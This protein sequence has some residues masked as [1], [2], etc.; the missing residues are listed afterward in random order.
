MKKKIFMQ[1]KKTKYKSILSFLSPSKKPKQPIEDK[2]LT[3]STNTNTDFIST[4]TNEPQCEENESLKLLKS[5]DLES[6]ITN[7]S[8]F[9]LSSEDDI[10]C[11][12]EPVIDSSKQTLPSLIYT[13]KQNNNEDSINNSS[14]NGSLSFN[15][16]LDF[17]EDLNLKSLHK[18]RKENIKKLE[19]EGKNLYDLPFNHPKYEKYPQIEKIEIKN[20]E[21]KKLTNFMQQYWEVKKNYFDFILFFKNG[22]F[23]ELFYDDAIFMADVFGLRVTKR[24]SVPMAG[25]PETKFDQWSTKVLSEN[26]KVARVEQK[27]KEDINSKKILQRELVD[28]ITPG[29]IPDINIDGVSERIQDNSMACHLSSIYIS[30]FNREIFDENLNDVNLK[31]KFDVFIYNT[32]TNSCVPYSFED[33]YPFFTLKTILINNNVTEIISNKQIPSLK[34]QKPPSFSTNLIPEVFTDFQKKAYKNLLA[35]LNFLKKPLEI[36]IVEQSLDEKKMFICATSLIN[37]SIDRLFKEL[38]YC[39]NP[40]GKRLLRQ[41]LNFPSCNLDTIFRRNLACKLL[42]EISID[43]YSEDWNDIKNVGDIDRQ[44]NRFNGIYKLNDVKNLLESLKKMLFVM[45]KARVF[46][47]ME[48]VEEMDLKIECGNIDCKINENS[49]TPYDKIGFYKN[50]KKNTEFIKKNIKNLKLFIEDFEKKYKFDEISINLK[51]PSENQIKLSQNL[52][53]IIEDLTEHKE[54]Y[55]KQLKTKIIYK[56]IGKDIFQLEMDASIKVSSDLQLVSATKK[57]KRYYTNS[58]R[59]L[60]D[61]YKFAEHKIKQANDSVLFDAVNEILELKEN[62]LSL[63]KYLAMGDVYFSM[64]ESKKKGNIFP[65]FISDCCR[66]YF[67]YSLKTKNNVLLIE[68]INVMEDISDKKSKIDKNKEKFLLEAENISHPL[69]DYTTT[70]LKLNTPTVILTGPNMGGKSTFLRTLGLTAIISQAGFP[71]KGSKIKFPIF[72]KIFTRIGAFDNLLKKESTFKIEMLE[73]SRILNK[74]DRNSLVLVDELGRGT[75]VGDGEAICR[76]VLKKAREVGVTFFLST[77]YHR[78]VI[79]EIGIHCI[80]KN[81]ENLYEQKICISEDKNNNTRCLNMK[82]KVENNVI[83]FL[84]QLGEGLC[85]GSEGIEVARLAGI[86]DEILK[87]AENSKKMLMEK[88]DFLKNKN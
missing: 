85:T 31:F 55:E 50:N 26:R 68:D 23:Y 30:I 75:S 76:G 6:E 41:I 9:N 45:E 34:I 52:Y 60:A 32:N 70:S 73:M 84:Y 80:N 88:Y 62:I 67:K 5:Q 1:P 18:K 49:E 59:E 17:S 15:E 37:L 61:K 21:L 27:E 72:N 12:N 51:V 24:G 2:L 82:Y 78:M 28:A 66:E 74:M 39:K 43:K 65:M 83:T 53:K 54:K 8:L 36:E 4:S 77:H 38:D 29:T 81:N 79:E 7:N 25:I 16:N 42:G 13:M 20:S 10:F 63:C 57:S 87:D 44:L 46:E 48:F 69:F 64:C 58:I 40:M 71:I 14:F 35:Y 47:K 33:C 86:K 22:K 11:N 3:T 56:N 19:N